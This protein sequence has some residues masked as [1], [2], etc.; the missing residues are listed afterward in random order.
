MYGDAYSVPV[1]HAPSPGALASFGRPGRFGTSGRR[2]AP[3]ARDSGS[4]SAWMPGS[5]RPGA[6][7]SEFGVAELTVAVWAERCRGIGRAGKTALGEMKVDVSAGSGCNDWASAAQA[8]PADRMQM[9][10]ESDK[11]QFMTNRT[12][13]VR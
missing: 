12:E 13:D 11:E 8:M 2:S 3:R 1:S 4:A 6:A 9:S 10:D 7:E 5:A